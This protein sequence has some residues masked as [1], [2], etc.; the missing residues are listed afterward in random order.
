MWVRCVY[1]VCVCNVSVC[2]CVFTPML[3]LLVTSI[4][5]IYIAKVMSSLIDWLALHFCLTNTPS[6]PDLACSN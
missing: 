5:H 2:V 6:V 3:M 1:V 4:L